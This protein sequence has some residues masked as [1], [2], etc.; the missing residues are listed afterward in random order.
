M[1]GV[2]GT[3]FWLFL[4]LIC[5]IWL[6]RGCGSRFDKWRDYRDDR[7]ND[8]QEWW[9][10]RRERRE[11]SDDEE[12]RRRRW[13]RRRQD[14]AEDKKQDTLSNDVSVDMDGI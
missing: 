7:R 9:E 11:F 5:I 1:P 13:F 2:K 14:Q 10:Q 3:L 6:T 4:V 12:S 8:R